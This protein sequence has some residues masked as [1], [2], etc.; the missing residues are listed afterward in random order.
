MNLTRNV[1][2]GAL[3]VAYMTIKLQNSTW[4]KCLNLSLTGSHVRTYIHTHIRTEWR[5]FVRTYPRM[6]NRKNYMPPSIIRCG[7]ITKMDSWNSINPTNSTNPPNSINPTNLVCRIKIRTYHI[8]PCVLCP[9][10]QTSELQMGHETLPLFPPSMQHASPLD[11]F[12][13]YT[14]NDHLYNV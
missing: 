13:L 6:E 1:S 9:H 3:A 5:T 11:C 4:N 14:V 7:A 12:C 2:T 10:F 8:F